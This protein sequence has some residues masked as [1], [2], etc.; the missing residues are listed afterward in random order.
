[1]KQAGGSPDE[2]RLEQTPYPFP[3]QLI[4]ALFGHKITLYRFNHTIAVWLKSEQV[5]LSPPDPLTLTTAKDDRGGGDNCSYKTGK[6]PVKLSPSTNQHH[7]VLRA[8][9]LP[10]TQ[11]LV[12]KHNSKEVS[13]STDLLTPSSSVSSDLACD[14]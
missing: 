8:G 7:N 13:H 6:T 12:S 3:T 4:L 2:A 11:P 10:V 1:M 9:Y 5:G 14:H